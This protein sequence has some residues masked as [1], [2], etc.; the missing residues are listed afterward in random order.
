LEAKKGWERRVQ[1][2]ARRNWRLKRR[3]GQ[4]LVGGQREVEARKIG[5]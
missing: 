3:G 1:V 4:K 2:E 5:G